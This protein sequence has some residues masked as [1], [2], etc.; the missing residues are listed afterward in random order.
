MPANHIYQPAINS[1]VHHH[2]GSRMQ[3]SN[4][5]KARRY[6]EQTQPNID[7]TTYTANIT[8]AFYTNTTSTPQTVIVPTSSGNVPAQI[9]FIPKNASV[10]LTGFLTTLAASST[11]ALIGFAISSQRG[12][13][14]PDSPYL[15]LNII[16]ESIAQV[17]FEIAFT[18]LIP[19]SI[20][21]AS[22]QI[23]LA[24]VYSTITNIP[25]ILFKALTCV[26]YTAIS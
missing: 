11:P 10:V 18:D 4:N 5:L 1:P 14:F 25:C 2:S 16:T 23:T 17:Y 8:G 13:P 22:L 20:H 3:D 9:R 19:G 6:L 24:S 26:S 12:T 15:Y 21:T 7:I